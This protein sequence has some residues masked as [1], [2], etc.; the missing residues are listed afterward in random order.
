MF[1]SGGY[2]SI[3]IEP[4]FEFYRCVYFVNNCESDSLS[5]E[6]DGRPCFVMDLIRF[7]V[8]LAFVVVF[9]TLGGGLKRDS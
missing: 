8:C 5:I 1:V 6:F 7:S 4:G 3:C 2:W 9:V